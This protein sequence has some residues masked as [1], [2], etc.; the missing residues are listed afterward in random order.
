MVIRSLLQLEVVGGIIKS[1]SAQLKAIRNRGKVT[2][3]FVSNLP[4]STSPQFFL[5]SDDDDELC[6][7][8]V[9]GGRR[10]TER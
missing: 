6:T 8:K 2:I 3:S 4:N 9:Q 10:F 5:L 1:G 7:S